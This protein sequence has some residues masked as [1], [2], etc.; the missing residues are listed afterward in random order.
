MKLAARI[1]FP[2]SAARWRVRAF[3]IEKKKSKRY[4][5]LG[6]APFLYYARL[7]YASFNNHLNPHHLRYEPGRRRT[8]DAKTK[9]YGGRKEGIAN[10]IVQPCNPIAAT[11][12]LRFC[13]IFVSVYRC[14]ELDGWA[15]L[16]VKGRARGTGLES[17]QASCWWMMGGWVDAVIPNSVV[18]LDGLT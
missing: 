8:A 11:A 4:H 1:V 16:V 9:N 3:S 7:W 15:L 2:V 12:S 17:K 10:A 5:Q 6:S 18:E 14:I 13:K